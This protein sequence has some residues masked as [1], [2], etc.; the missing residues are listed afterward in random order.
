MPYHQTM[1]PRHSHCV[2]HLINVEQHQVAA[3]PHTNPADLGHEFLN[4]KILYT[5]FKSK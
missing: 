5:V 4:K 2:V 1:S 3:D